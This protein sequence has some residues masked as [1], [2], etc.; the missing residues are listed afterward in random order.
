MKYLLSYP[1]S[2]N[3]L[4]RFFIEVL[5]ETPTIGVQGTA[6]DIPL[7]KNTYTMDIS[8]NI[9]S[10]TQY[11]LAQCYQKF[12]KPIPSPKTD[13][14]LIFL[15]RSP[16]ECLIRQNGFSTWNENMNWYSYNAYFSLVDSYLSFPGKKCLLFYE[17][18][19]TNRVSFIIQLYNF[20]GINDCDKLNYVLK[21]L[22]ALFVQS[23][24]GKGRYW[25]GVRSNGNLVFYYPRIT[26]KIKPQFD[27]YINKQLANPSYEFIKYK[28]NLT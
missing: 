25:G 18:I 10:D 3:H 15:L 8:F 6:E 13:D 16:R 9:S 11:D 19:I 14:T 7:Y 23:I 24:N 21:N 2:G 17:D 4:V 5:C 20:L 28:Y 22:D 27:E 1:R 12:H 26:D